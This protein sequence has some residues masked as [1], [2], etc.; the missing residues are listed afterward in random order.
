MATTYFGCTKQKPEPKKANAYYG[1][2]F[3]LSGIK[4]TKTS[5]TEEE[6]NPV[7]NDIK[8]RIERLVAKNHH[9][10]TKI[11]PQVGEKIESLR[12]RIISNEDQ[13]M[14]NKMKMERLQKHIIKRLEETNDLSDECK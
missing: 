9:R 13:N 1:E 6:I 2:L 7:T 14:E 3:K 5:K 10:E 4:T 11:D 12:Q 8:A